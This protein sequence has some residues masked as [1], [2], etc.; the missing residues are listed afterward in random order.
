MIIVVELNTNL[1][2]DWNIK[3][4]DLTV[5][6]CNISISPAARVLYITTSMHHASRSYILDSCKIT[7]D[8][9]NCRAEYTQQFFITVKKTRAVGNKRQA[10]GF[11]RAQA[12][13]NS[14]A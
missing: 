13:Q 3:L 6:M 1:G 8:N 12:H 9:S 11:G 14:D 10:L 7:N 4:S 2:T 5:Y